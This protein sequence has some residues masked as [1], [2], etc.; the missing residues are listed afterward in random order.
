MIY[1]LVTICISATVVC[2]YIFAQ[3]KNKAKELQDTLDLKDRIIS[4]MQISMNHND[5]IHKTLKDIA[6]SQSIDELNKFYDK[7]Y[8]PGSGNGST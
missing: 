6:Q 5:E 3:A 1:V 4:A 2:G 7:I 8:K